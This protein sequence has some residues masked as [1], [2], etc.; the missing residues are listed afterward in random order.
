MH[1]VAIDLL[2]LIIFDLNFIHRW[3]FKKIY[4]STIFSAKLL[5]IF[6]VKFLIN[7][8]FKTFQETLSNAFLI[9]SNT[10][11]GPFLNL[12]IFSN[13]KSRIETIYVLSKL[14][15]TIFCQK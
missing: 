10:I 11:F 12:D 4:C 9:S 14:F 3:V 15:L 13:A 1:P 5:F 7:K 6:L 2:N 8:S